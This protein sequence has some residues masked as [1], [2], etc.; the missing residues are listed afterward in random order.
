MQNFGL[1]NKD[2]L[3]KQPLISSKKDLFLF[4]RKNTDNSEYIKAK[5]VANLDEANDIDEE[6]V[7]EK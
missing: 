3:K 7:D 5:S 4:R 6:T 1:E 2:E